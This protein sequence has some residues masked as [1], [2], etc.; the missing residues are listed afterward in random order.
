MLA[1]Q[2]RVGA[3]RGWLGRTFR[4][5]MGRSRAR[6]ELAGEVMA[7]RRAVR[8]WESASEGALLENRAGAN[9]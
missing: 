7:I 3:S 4:G 8:K 5:D 1:E 2:V 9:G 6:G